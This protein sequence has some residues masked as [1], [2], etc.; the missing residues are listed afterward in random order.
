MGELGATSDPRELVPGDA[1]AV[2]DAAVQWRARSEQAELAAAS[3]RRL[4]IPEDWTGHAADA[5][6]T[7]VA[8]VA[9]RWMKV[10]GV[11]A[12]A[13]SA[14]EAYASELAWA[15][16]QAALAIE[17]WRQAQAQTHAA[18]TS[19][20][21][22][23]LRG[24]DV[25]EPVDPGAPLRVQ[26]RAMLEDARL[27]VQVA[28]DSATAS[29]RAAAGE[30]DLEPDVWLAL[31]SAVTS[32]QLLAALAGLDA[33]GIASLVRMRPDVANLLAGADPTE[34]AA[35]WGPLDE[36]QQD[37]LITALPAVIGNL[38]GVAYGACH[39]ANRIY[40]EQQLKAARS[41]VSQLEAPQTGGAV[42][43]TSPVP[44]TSSRRAP[45]WRRSKTLMPGSSP[46]RT[47]PSGF[48]FRSLVVNRR[49]PRY[50]SGT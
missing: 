28:G 3:L 29:L 15:Q 42:T 17:K 10:T 11:L 48:S 23:S 8:S 36:T 16:N 49:W 40:L 22:A 19:P 24:T 21:G 37:A 50:L 18:L 34:V 41:E 25:L 31:G 2:T 47:G 13:A 5:F 33:D 45:N 20:A 38:G 26:A 30:P 7:R 32:G 39:E 14:L 1:V 12:A 43:Q 27:R 46:L 9:D 6:E 4:R 44:V 35:W